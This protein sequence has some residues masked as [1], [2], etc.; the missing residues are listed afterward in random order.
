M[1]HDVDDA[2]FVRTE[3]CRE[4]IHTQCPSATVR[5]IVH[6]LAAAAEDRRC[7]VLNQLLERFFSFIL[8]SVEYIQSSYRLVSYWR[9]TYILEWQSDYSAMPI[10]SPAQRHTFRQHPL[11]L[12]FLFSLR[13][14]LAGL[15]CRRVRQDRKTSS[16]CKGSTSGRVVEDVREVLEDC[17]LGWRRRWSVAVISFRHAEL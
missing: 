2:G 7:A 17:L 3:I 5:L 4:L 15:I 1:R 11:I 14:Q 13:R 6:V 16:T 9:R 10:S 8:S 12:N